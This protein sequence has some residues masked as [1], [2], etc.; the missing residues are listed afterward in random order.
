MK[1][2]YLNQEEAYGLINSWTKT[3]TNYEIQFQNKNVEKVV[4]SFDGEQ[5]VAATVWYTIGNKFGTG[6]IDLRQKSL[7]DEP[8]KPSGI[9]AIIPSK[10]TSID[11][12]LEL[13]LE[14]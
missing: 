14:V 13:E 6:F 3:Q 8:R 10:K 2:E 7:L 5:P 9:P 12:K 1:K 4:V 11:S